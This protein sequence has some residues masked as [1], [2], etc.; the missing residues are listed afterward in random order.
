MQE[1]EERGGCTNLKE[2]DGEAEEEEEGEGEEKASEEAPV[3]RDSVVCFG[4]MTCASGLLSLLL[5]F[6]RSAFCSEVLEYRASSCS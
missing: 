5:L 2:R 4:P 6:F 3:S 1:E